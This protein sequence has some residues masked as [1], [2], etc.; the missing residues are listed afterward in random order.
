MGVMGHNNVIHVDDHN[1]FIDELLE[2]VIHH[3]LEHFQAVS[4]T[5]EH[6]KRFEQASVC[7]KAAFHSSLSLILTL[8]YPHLMSILVK[9]FAL[10]PETLL[11]MSGIRGRG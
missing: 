6:D 8:L 4:E 7:P 3:H 2:D 11:R 5:K 1:S 9:Y 10:A